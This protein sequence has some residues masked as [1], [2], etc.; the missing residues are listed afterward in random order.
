MTI[1]FN[2]VRGGC[3][4]IGLVKIFRLQDTMP[5]SDAHNERVSL[6]AL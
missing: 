5:A 4:G 3:E 6:P 2:Y 1:L